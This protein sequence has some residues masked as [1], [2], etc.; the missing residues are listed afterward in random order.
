[1][2]K[3]AIVVALV[4]TTLSGCAIVPLGGYGHHKGYGYN[5]GYGYHDSGRH[6]GDDGRRYRR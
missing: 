1:M 2:K 6:H 4:I 5:K 3:L